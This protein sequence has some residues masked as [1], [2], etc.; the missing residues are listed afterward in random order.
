M[1]S[2]T[3]LFHYLF[4]Y[5]YLFYLSPGGL[6]DLSSPTRDWTWAAWVRVRSLT[7]RPPRQLPHDAIL[8][9]Q[10]NV[11]EGQMWRIL[12]PSSSTGSIETNILSSPH[13]NHADISNLPHNIC[14]R[15]HWEENIQLNLT[16]KLQGL[17]TS[18]LNFSVLNRSPMYSPAACMRFYST[19]RLFQTTLALTRFGCPVKAGF[20]CFQLPLPHDSVFLWI[21]FR[22]EVILLIHPDSLTVTSTK[23]PLVWLGK[24]LPSSISGTRKAR[25]HLCSGW[26][27]AW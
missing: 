10:H 8:N 27:G 7:T 12:L 21:L 24:R 18:R 4:I 1:G 25:W 16:I 6:E 17:A 11:V 14:I 2:F 23:A 13:K 20:L 15:K 9:P 26:S 5:F 22:E 3:T 19:S